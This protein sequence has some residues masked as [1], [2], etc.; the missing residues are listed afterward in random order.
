MPLSSQKHVSF[1]RVKRAISKNR[2]A[3]VFIFDIVPRPVPDVPSPRRYSEFEF[4]RREVTKRPESIRFC[5]DLCGARSAM[6]ARTATVRNCST[7]C[8]S[9]SEASQLH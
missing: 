7:G 5:T 6:V 2:V 3:V 1:G 8:C 4:H 9:V